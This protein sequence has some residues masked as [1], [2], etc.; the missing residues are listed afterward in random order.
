MC[1]QRVFRSDP[2]RSPLFPV[3]H[4]YLGKAVLVCVISLGLFGGCDRGHA[5]KQ[6]DRARS[7]WAQALGR[8]L[9]LVGHRKYG[10][11]CNSVPTW[12]NSD[13]MEG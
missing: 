11:N 2:I 12:P 9:S 10:S 7:S 5:P 13:V 1:V 6:V 4:R 8:D 3:P